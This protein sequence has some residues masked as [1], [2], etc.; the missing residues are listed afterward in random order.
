VPPFFRSQ[1]AAFVLLPVAALCWAGNHVI[2]RAAGGHVPPA[3]MA[4]LRWIIVALVVLPFAG[5]HL[6]ADWPR[7]RAHPWLMV[8]F[9]VTGG[10]AFG[11]LQFVA[12]HF[13][14]ALN[15][16]VVGSVAPAF[17]V[18]ASWLLFRERLSPLQL[19]GVLVSLSG[20]LAIVSRLD[21][22]TLAAFSFNVG[23]LIIIANM[24]LW[25]VYASCLRVRPG[26]H[27]AS[28]ILAMAV[29]SALGN[30]PFAAGEYAFGYVLQP[31]WLTVA[32]TLYAAFITTILAYVA[33]N[34]AVDI[35]GAPRA[36]AFL[37]TIPLFS[38]L[39]ATTLLGERIEAFH[40]VGFALI[41]GGVTL[42][43]RPSP[44]SGYQG[45]ASG[46]RPQR[47]LAPDP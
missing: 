47:N 20:V 6:R 14:T 28:F 40:I 21:P 4:V 38:A 42:V 45:Q 16:G 39:L 36:S 2:A 33:W 13:T 34:A 31:T 43:A 10:G 15:M 41:L 35:V 9:A 29:L 1:A 30:L 17:I 7:I 5:A 37:H 22:A 18:A 19:A 12:L 23:D 25:A 44:A 11:T 24:T 8:L 32:T 46:P 27:A 3:S 26:M